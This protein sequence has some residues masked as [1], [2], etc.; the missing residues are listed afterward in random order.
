MGGAARC[1]SLLPGLSSALTIATPM[2]FAAPRLP[3]LFA[4]CLLAG[5]PFAARS[6]AQ[7][8]NESIAR[9]VR[10]M[11]SNEFAVRQQATRQLA[12][13]GAAA[14]PHLLEAL[15]SDSYELRARASRLLD[16]FT[17][18]ELADYVQQ[19]GA[20]PLGH[21][22]VRVL[23]TRARQ[24]LHTACHATQADE[25]F[26]LWNIDA[27][28][29]VDQFGGRLEAARDPEEFQAA[30]RSLREFA[31]QLAQFAELV[32]QFADLGLTLDPHDSPARIVTELCALA[33]RDGHA[34][35]LD[36]AQNYLAAL[37]SLAQ[38]I[39][40]SSASEQAGRR[41]VAHRAAWS[42]GALVFLVELFEPDSA[43]ARLLT[44]RC[45]ISLSDLRTSF[46]E[47]L[48]A[49]GSQAFTWGVGK[50]HIAEMLC[51]TLGEWP[52]APAD[53]VVGA[54]ITRISETIASG[55]KPRALCCLD[56]IRA[57]RTLQQQGLALD[58]G[59]G[60]QLSERLLYFALRA[61]TPRE[62]HPARSVHEKFLV[63]LE[64]GLTPNDA[65]FPQQL[66]D[67]HLQA[68]EPLTDADRLALERFARIIERLARWRLSCQEPALEPYCQVLHAACPARP[69]QLAAALANLETIERA[70]REAIQRGDKEPLITQLNR[71]A[72]SQNK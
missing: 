31:R 19:T 45:H 72:N 42:R 34:A 67:R 64:H 46:L 21:R 50:T 23:S 32:E 7:D 40:Q 69:E 3:L 27:A 47:A 55:D 28:K 30:L 48:A 26:A 44:Q 14:L 37:R 17:F 39:D 1:G 24:Y 61:A 6:W 9:L 15:S 25:L 35:Q 71:W 38:H 4:L 13:V 52:E 60:G 41:E 12:D 66:W 51:D 29:I 2:P 62:F 59:L 54:L 8:R 49:P 63:L 65:H 68:A 43:S 56:A 16:D 70:E 20:P 53:G 36:F 58:A 22:A 10:Q 18:A 5:G 11:N 57:C 33:L